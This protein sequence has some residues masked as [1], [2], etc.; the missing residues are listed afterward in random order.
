MQSALL[1]TLLLILFVYAGSQAA[2]SSGEPDKFFRQ[3]I[4]LNDQEIGEI[5]HGKAVAKVLDSP[6]PDEV[7]V[8]GSVYVHS[9]PDRYLRLASNT[10]ELRKLPNYLALQNSVIRRSFPISPDLLSRTVPIRLC[11]LR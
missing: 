6:T 3:F 10:D 5:A 2:N 9:T 7:F 8:F 1:I 4:G 11:F